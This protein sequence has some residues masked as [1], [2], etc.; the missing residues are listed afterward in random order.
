[1]DELKNLK[2]TIFGCMCVLGTLTVCNAFILLCVIL[3]MI[4]GGK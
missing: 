4:F 1:M 3:T 2:A